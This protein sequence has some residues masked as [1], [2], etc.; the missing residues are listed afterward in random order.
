M[1]A[2]ERG[3]ILGREPRAKRILEIIQSRAGKTGRLLDIGCGLG[4]MTGIFAVNSSY[5]VGIDTDLVF[6]RFAH[7]NHKRRVAFL[8]ADAQYLPF[9][10]GTFETAIANYVLECLPSKN[11]IRAMREILRILV[12]SGYSYVTIPNPLHRLMRAAYV[13]VW[14]VAYGPPPGRYALSAV[15]QLKYFSSV[16]RIHD[17]TKDLALRQDLPGLIFRIVRNQ[18]MIK[19]LSL[20]WA[21]LLKKRCLA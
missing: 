19:A 10:H 15:L 7:K 2:V 12:V 14:G 18:R 20:S 9:R 13:P 4:I 5:A 6:L 8:L 16:F 17:V 11:Q 21:F 3:W 1:T